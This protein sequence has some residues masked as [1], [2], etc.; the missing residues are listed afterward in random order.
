M[1]ALGIMGVTTPVERLTRGGVGG[2]STLGA[3]PSRSPPYPAYV[4]HLEQT[5]RR[6]NRGL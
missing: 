6:A 1:T 5:S 3:A 2:S 4:P